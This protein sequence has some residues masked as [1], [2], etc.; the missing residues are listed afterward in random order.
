MNVCKKLRLAFVSGN[1]RLKLL[2]NLHGTNIL[3]TL[4]NEES[5]RVACA[6][7]RAQSLV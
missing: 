6:T 7:F 3:I 1:V 5:E 2:C 4:I